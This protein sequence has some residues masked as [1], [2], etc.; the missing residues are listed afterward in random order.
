[1]KTYT[2]KQGEM[3]DYVAWKVLGSSDY[4]EAL[5]NANR[6]HAATFIFPAGVE[7]VI[8]DIAEEQ[9]VSSLPP[10]KRA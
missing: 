5:I 6:E 2:T 8:P 4:V 1:M 7:L 9:K 3:W 10:W